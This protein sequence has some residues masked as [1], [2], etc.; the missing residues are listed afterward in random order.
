MNDVAQ[1]RKDTGVSVMMYH[2]MVQVM[3]L[4]CS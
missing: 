4:L 1:D 3:V 2:D